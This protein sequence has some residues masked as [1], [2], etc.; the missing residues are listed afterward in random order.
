MSPWLGFSVYHPDKQNLSNPPAMLSFP[1]LSSVLVG[2]KAPDVD[3]CAFWVL[4]DKDRR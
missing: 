3:E 1:E 4:S 2:P